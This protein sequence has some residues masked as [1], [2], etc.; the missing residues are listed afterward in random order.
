MT[1]SK[2][3]QLLGGVMA[4]GLLL[5][6]SSISSA[7]DDDHNDGRDNGRNDN[8]S[9]GRDNGRNDNRSDGRDYG[10][11]YGRDYGHDG[12]DDDGQTL[13]VWAGDKAHEAP[14]FLAVVDFDRN[15]PRYGKIIR[16]VPLPAGAIGKGAVGNEPHHA[17]LSHDG[18]TLALGGLLSFLRSQPQVFFFDVSH[19]RHPKFMSASNPT[20]ASITDEFAPLKNGGFLA[21][22]MGGTNGAHPGRVVE[23][24]ARGKIVRSL[25]V[26]TDDAQHMFNPHGI[27]ID[28]AANLMVTSDY[29]CPVSTLHAGGGVPHLDGSVRVW[30]LAKRSVVRTVAVGEGVGTMD[31]KLIPGDPLHRAFTAGMND[32]QLYLVDTRTGTARPV[33]DFGPYAVQAVP[34]PPIW[35]QLLVVNKAGTRLFVTLNFAGQAGKVV[36]LDIRDP[37]RPTPV[38]ADPAVSVVDLGL[39]SGPHYL[40]LTSDDK[41]L[42]V[43]DYFLVE[44]LIPSGVINAEGDMKVH[45]IN[46]SR[47]GMELDKR[48]ELDFSHDVSTG[49]AHPHA[50]IVLNGRDD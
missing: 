14:D 15:S 50:L 20:D 13:L 11:D 22:F 21:T 23:Y 3:R 36:M 29:V 25:P 1:G 33:F 18:H 31:V 16:T 2:L 44:D 34:E 40:Q 45:V 32:H 30:D 6:G 49:P 46:V 43:S 27:S 4:V 24:D 12:R 35:P 39:N 19:P 5:S 47:D 41:R 42:V 17:G 37:E 8:R 10:H 38:G 26:P 28:E 48:F 7:H 9:D